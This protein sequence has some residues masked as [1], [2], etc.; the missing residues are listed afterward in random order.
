MCNKCRGQNSG[1]IICR[2]INGLKLIMAGELCK[3]IR[4]SL[5]RVTPFKSELAFE[6]IRL[7]ENY[8][9]S[10]FESDLIFIFKSERERET[11]NP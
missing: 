8:H 3:A 7:E 5:T 2:L 4:H 11:V 9:H 10:G 6:L 1:T